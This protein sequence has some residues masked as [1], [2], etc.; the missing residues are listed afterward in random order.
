MSTA[1]RKFARPLIILG[2]AAAISAAAAL[3]LRPP[4]P[5]VETGTV[6]RGPVAEALSDQGYARMREAYVVSAPVAGDAARIL[7]HVGDPVE[8]GVTEITRIA[9]QSPALL[10][11]RSRSQAQAQVAVAEAQSRAAE[12]ALRQA[13]AEARRADQ[14]LARLRPL[15]AQGFVSASGLDAAEAAARASRAA[16]AAASARR[17]A[18]L[19]D[20]AASRA[21]LMPGGS[22]DAA[23]R[24]LAPATGFVTRVLHQSAGPVAA[25][26]PLV[27]I[28]DRSDLEGAI[29]FLSQDAVRI[30]EGMRAEIFDWGG[31]GVLQALV[32]RVEPQAFTKVSALGVEEQRVLVLLQFAGPASVHPGLAPGYRIWGR[33]ILREEASAL[34]APVGALVR[35]HAGW[36]VY[37]LEGRRAVMRPVRVGAIDGD[38]AEILQGL[39]V[40]DRLIIYPSDEIHD[41][42]RVR[43]A[44]KAS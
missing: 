38:H 40:G 9:P 37:R 31:P 3:A 29:E 13:E 33:V 43:V 17:S 10:D 20:L 1:K 41:G 39:S 23:V 25:A 34:R 27:E 35:Q 12:A 26:A 8:A 5:V 4:T 28:S 14:D 11:Q 36:A 24:V 16:R 44:G 19:A 30:R 7:L 15:A 42:R 18:S 21:A 22:G 6:S 2:A 32:R